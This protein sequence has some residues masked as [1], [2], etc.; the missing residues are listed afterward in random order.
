MLNILITGSNGQLGSEFRLACHS[1]PYFNIIFT[2]I[3]ELDITSKDS[4]DAFFRSNSIDAV[5]NCAAYTAVDK[6]EEETEKAMLINKEAVA[7][8]AAA[9][10]ANHAYMIHI[11]TDYVF[12]GSA[13]SPYRESDPSSP[14]SSYGRSKL[15]GEMAMLNCLEKGMII[16]T[17]WLYSTFGNNFVKT[18]LKKGAEKGELNVVDDQVGSP[19]YARD[20]AVAILQILPSAISRNELQVFH[21]ANEGHCSWYEFAKAA[22]ELAAIPCKI[23]P[24]GSDKYP[25]IA[26]RPSYSILDKSKIKEQ[27]GIIIPNWKDSLADCIKILNNE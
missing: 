12:D 5:I 9:C 11:S 24:V 19:T 18:I 2:D 21:Y 1:Y 17:S 4:V 3:E 26:P 6:A 14:T 10:K 23:N 22:I 8:L 7:T 20:L 16:R 27:F 25:Q 13:R 15:A